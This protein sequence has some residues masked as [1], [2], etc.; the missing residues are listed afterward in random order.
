MRLADFAARPS[1]RTA[2]L[3]LTMTPP[4]FTRLAICSIAIL[5]GTCFAQSNENYPGYDFG[6]SPQKAQ[7]YWDAPSKPDQ[8]PIQPVGLQT[9]SA[10]AAF[11]QIRYATPSTSFPVSSMSPTGSA[12]MVPRG[13]NV[14]NSMIPKYNYPSMSQ[15]A[16]GM[17]RGNNATHPFRRR[18]QTFQRGGPASP[19]ASRGNVFYSEPPRGGTTNFGSAALPPQSQFVPGAPIQSGFQGGGFDA[20]GFVP[21]PIGVTG[22]A[23]MAQ[24]LPIPIQNLPAAQTPI[25]SEAQV[26]SAPPAAPAPPITNGSWSSGRFDTSGNYAAAENY[27]YDGN[28]LAGNPPATLDGYAITAP[29]QARVLGTRNPT[30]FFFRWERLWTS[31]DAPS[32]G[33]V[34]DPASEG[35]FIANGITA[36][37]FNSLSGDFIDDRPEFGDRIEFGFADP[38]QTCGWMGSVLKIDQAKSTILPGGS[39]QFADPWGM[40]LGFSDGND[41][42]V[43]DDLNGNGIY[44]RNGRDLGTPDDLNP[45]TFLPTL[46]GI[47]DTPSA[48]DNGDLVSFVPVFDELEVSNQINIS[49]LELSRFRSLGGSQRVNFLLGVRYLDIDE[50]FFLRGSGSFLDEMRVTTNV[51][52]FIIG[53]QI[54]IGLCR[55]RGHWGTDASIRAL[56]GVNRQRGRQTAI[57]AS[58]ASDSMGAANGPLNLS[59]SASSSTQS[60]TQ[61]SPVVE[62]RAGVWYN[63]TSFSAIRLGYSGFYV[64]GISRA[65]T[66]IDYR[67]PTFGFDID[68]NDDL[69]AHA[70]TAGLHFQF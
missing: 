48:Q 70:F 3:G 2:I 26:Q 38:N 14:G 49:G 61:F 46:D 36:P 11:G 47:P 67:V 19:L 44:G 32:V 58:N 16:I 18:M 64:G 1:R 5:S 20:G 52:N 12:A 69:I 63:V 60:S 42:G 31:I 34:G 41:D 68:N 22:S 51:E 39:I 23:P 65:A 66:S 6:V 50:R 24:T 15:T 35:V 45:G 21:Q 55:S 8:N 53:P 10:K 43:D 62:L 56:A 27:R 17:E 59:P 37:Y 25:V 30:G 29:P 4:R 33:E 57:L 28:F 13:A 9:N 7:N 54:G 40:L